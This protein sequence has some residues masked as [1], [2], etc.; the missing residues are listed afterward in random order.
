[1]IVEYIMGRSWLAGTTFIEKCLSG[2]AVLSDIDEHVE[3]WHNGKDGIGLELHEF[4]GMREEYSQW[5]TQP[6]ALPS[7][8]EARKPTKNKQ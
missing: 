7:I 8:L 2:N 6:S 4:R 3:N 1:M 5:G